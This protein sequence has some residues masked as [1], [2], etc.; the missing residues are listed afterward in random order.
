MRIRLRGF[1]T[2]KDSHLRGFD[3]PNTVY[4]VYLVP[5]ATRITAHVNILVTLLRKLYV[6]NIHFM[7]FVTFRI[8][9]N[10]FLGSFDSLS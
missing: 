8:L 1:P 5:L 7:Y 4:L 10:Y 6:I 3:W 9:I 2:E